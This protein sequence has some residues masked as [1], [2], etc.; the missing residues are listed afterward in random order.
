MKKSL[1]L[2]AIIILI[3]GCNQSIQENTPAQTQNTPQNMERFQRPDFGQ[4]ERTPDIMGI[5][6]SVVGNEVTILELATPNFNRN[7]NVE[8]TKP[9]GQTGETGQTGQAPTLSLGTNTGGFPGG[10]RGGFGGS[11]TTG[12]A[13]DQAAMIEKLKERSV[14]EATLTIPVGIRMLKPGTPSNTTEPTMDEA[15]ISDVKK[16][17]MVSIWLNQDVTDR[18]I[19]EFVLIR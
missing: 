6:K 4:P 15:N 2:L 1:I 14:A 17:Q 16:D 8:Q 10:G 7:Q 18:K 12:T 5:V 11:R 19:A 9:A 13:E 3:T